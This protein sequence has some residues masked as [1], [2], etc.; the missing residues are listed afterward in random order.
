LDLVYCPDG[1]GPVP[2]LNIPFIAGNDCKLDN[3]IKAPWGDPAFFPLA[4]N[5]ARPFE[6]L[7]QTFGSIEQ[8]LRITPEL[9]LTSVTALYTSK[10]KSL[11][12]ATT[13]SNLAMILGDYNFSNHQVSQELRL[14]SDFTNSPLNFMVGGYYQSSKMMNKLVIDTNRKVG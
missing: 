7:N 14:T 5:N 2:P 12:L 8:N 3:N 6:N 11:H 4:P 9:T 1:T 10:V 13:S